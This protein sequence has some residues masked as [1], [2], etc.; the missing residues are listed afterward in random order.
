M[1]VGRLD[2]QSGKVEYCNAGHIPPLWLGGSGV[3]ELSDSDILIGPFLKADFHDASFTL[4]CGDAL[5]LFT[6]GLTEAE[7]DEGVEFGTSKL[8]ETLAPLHG[9]GADEVASRL[10]NGVLEFTDLQAL[11]DDL[12]LV[13]VS[14]ETAR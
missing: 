1:F 5:V 6:D 2:T 4:N 10:Q 7:N 11:G 12:T 3:T 13:V 14:R 9:R 8:G